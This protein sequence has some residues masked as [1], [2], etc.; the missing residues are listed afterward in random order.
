MKCNASSNQYL[1]LAPHDVHLDI[2]GT[3]G[4]SLKIS[5]L[6]DQLYTEPLPDTDD[7]WTWT[8]ADMKAK[9]F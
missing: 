8:M 9:Y 6:V 7:T 5:S 3:I 4:L 1:A 2:A